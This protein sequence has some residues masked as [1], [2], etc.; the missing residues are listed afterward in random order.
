MIDSVLES[1]CASVVAFGLLEDGILAELDISSTGAF[2]TCELRARRCTNGFET[3]NV[4]AEPTKLRS[5][6]SFERS[7][8]FTFACCAEGMVSSLSEDEYFLENAADLQRYLECSE[9]SAAIVQEGLPGSAGTEGCFRVIRNGTGRRSQ[10]ARYG[11]CASALK[12]VCESS[13][14]GPYRYLV[15]EAQMLRCFCRCRSLLERTVFLEAWICAMVPLV[16]TVALQR[17][18]KGPM[19]SLVDA[20]KKLGG[21]PGD[22]RQPDGAEL[23]AMVMEIGEI[24]VQIGQ[25]IRDVRKSI[26]GSVASFRLSA[27]IATMALHPGEIYDECLLS[28]RVEG[29]CAHYSDKNFSG[30]ENEIMVLDDA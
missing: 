16:G 24:Y 1:R 19:R 18:L 26:S 8:P 25:G 10:H 15:A 13:V 11:I 23:G 6:R 27:G 14:S 30:K 12:E 22:E 29:S 21:R 4:G 7:W 3:G 28:L 2:G 17:N 9:R 20:L 5:G